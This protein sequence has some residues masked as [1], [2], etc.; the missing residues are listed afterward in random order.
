MN[1]QARSPD[2]NA[3]PDSMVPI[4]AGEFVM[5][6]NDAEGFQTEKPAHTVFVDAFYMDKSSVTNAQYKAF[7]DA[8]P[9]WRKGNVREEYAAHNYLQHWSGNNYPSG[10]GNHPVV[11]VSWYAAMAYAKW[12][13]KRLPTEAEW[14]KAA[15]GGLAGKKFPWGNVID[16]SKANYDKNVGDT[17][18]LGRY[19]ANDYGLYDMAGNVWEWC[20]DEYDPDF[21]AKS[22]R[23]NPI[24]GSY[25]VEKVSKST[26]VLRGGSWSVSADNL[27]VTSRGG[28]IPSG[29]HPS[30]GFRCVKQSPD[31]DHDSRVNPRITPHPKRSTQEKPRKPREPLAT[32]NRNRPRRTPPRDTHFSFTFID[33]PRLAT[34][35]DESPRD[36]TVSLYNGDLEQSLRKADETH[37]ANAAREVASKFS[38]NHSLGFT[39]IVQI[40]RGKIKFAKGDEAGSPEELAQAIDLNWEEAKNLLYNGSIALWLKYTKHPQLA[41]IARNM[42]S[43]SSVGDSKNSRDISLEKLVQSLNPRIGHPVPKAD[44]TTINFGKVVGSEQKTT[45]LEIENAGRGFLYG[46]V[47]FAQALPG[48]RISSRRIRNRTF[49]T[50]TLDASLLAANKTHATV[51][52]IET[53]GGSL[54]VSIS[55]YVESPIQAALKEHTPD[56]VKLASL[57]ERDVDEAIEILYGGFLE[58][59]LTEVN[60]GNFANAARAVVSKYASSR[61]V[62][63][64]VIVQVLQGKV[65]FQRGGEAETPQQLSRLIDRNWEEAKA[66]LYSGF[67]AFWFKHT[68]Q[69]QFARTAEN[70]THL[71]RKKKDIG[72][73]VLV[74]S[75]DPQIGQPVLQVSHTS[76]NFGEVDKRAEKTVRVEIQNTGRGYLYGD[77]Q[78]AKAIPGLRISSTSIRGNTVL[79]VTLDTSRLADNK[80]HETALVIKTNGG[81]LRVPISCVPVNVANS[82][83][84]RSPDTETPT[85]KKEATTGA[86]T[87]R[88]G[89]AAALLGILLFLVWRATVENMTSIGMVLIP[90][91]EFQMGSNDS[92]ASNDEQPV[93]PVYVDAFYIDINEVTNARYKAFVDANPQWQKN[94]IPDKYHDGDYLLDWSG[95]SY[96]SGKGNH[97]VVY[98]SWYAAMAYAEWAGKRLPTEAEWE[99]AARGGLN[100]TKY[101]WG[102]ADPNGTQCNFADKNLSENW[103]ENWGENWADESANDG[104][105]YW[106]PVGSYPPNGYGL[107]DMAG[108]VWEWCLDEYDADFYARS[109]LRNPIAGGASASQIVNEFT[110]VKTSR[111]LRGG[112]WNNSAQNVRV[113]NRHRNTPSNT[114]GSRGFRCARDITP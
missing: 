104:Y 63:L 110:R 86:K 65:R 52:V 44:R 29:S 111:V 9:G 70:V 27:R 35:M 13:G 81:E 72:L 87:K 4:P 61:S 97:P 53:N 12:V 23:N 89:W 106:A 56:I 45:Y 92:E 80:M 21:Y 107:Y 90:A 42:V 78:L 49:L 84:S 96:P 66:L 14:E 1:S 17:T 10:K 26:C 47:R 99:K 46:D 73:E 74:Q 55:C 41:E 40:F 28:F 112:G 36:A 24:S 64:T 109:L 79:T 93:H 59:R 33:G 18:C 38:D 54:R 98:V 77:V 88:W 11:Y 108:N 62:G 85:P 3:T 30:Y 58:K 43:P 103:G 71:Y 102:N 57:M 75:L 2:S 32:V 20:L 100:G 60:K 83:T 8:N 50:L 6:C 22:Q 48:I 19:P 34:S 39:V 114:T 105:V 5:G 16:P 37:F 31:S 68:G 91:G 51:I 101:P 76:I 94:Y 113:A 69:R 15:R 95:N 67:F 7:V 25:T 82:P